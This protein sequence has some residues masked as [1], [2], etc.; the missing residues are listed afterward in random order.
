MAH[1]FVL[2][3]GPS[4]LNPNKN[5][6]AVLTNLQ[7]PSKNPKTGPMANLWLL[8]KDIAPH[9]AA[10]TG[11][12][13]AICG[14]CPLRTILRYIKGKLKQHR[15]CYVRPNQAALSVWK[16]FHRGRYQ[17]DNPTILPRNVRLGAYGEPVAIPLHIVQT[18]ANQVRVTGY[19]H[20]WRT[21]KDY[22]PY[23][24]ASIETPDEYREA[25]AAGWRTFR[26][27]PSPSSP[28]FP[29]EI[30]CPATKEGGNR[31]TCNDCCLCDGSRPYH[32]NGTTRPDRRKDIVVL[33]HG[34]GKHLFS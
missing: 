21:M 4:L 14:T 1:G 32:R 2:Y 10:A 26:S 12:D 11:D 29:N 3:D 25:K 18:I 28:L 6:I 5:I 33:A 15:K 34:P 31:T 27:I 8:V 16:A 9:V 22:R 23:L 19:T 30:L 17:H 20:Q 24:M 7:R 13:H